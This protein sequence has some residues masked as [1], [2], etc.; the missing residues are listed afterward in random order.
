[1][2]MI[3]LRLAGDVTRWSNAFSLAW[4]TVT[5]LGRNARLRLSLRYAGHQ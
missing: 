1:M 3:Q 2:V 5:K 4:L